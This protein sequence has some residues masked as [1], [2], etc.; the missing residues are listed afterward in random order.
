MNKTHTTHILRSCLSMLLAAVMLFSMV[1]AVF[2]TEDAA[3]STVQILR[4]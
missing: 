4:Q 3:D 1:P 2:A